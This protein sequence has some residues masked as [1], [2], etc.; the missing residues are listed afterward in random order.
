MKNLIKIIGIAIVIMLVLPFIV[1]KT[2]PADA[3]MAVCFLLFFAANPVVTCVVGI[4]SGKNI[5][6]N[7]YL[8]FVLPII[9]LL[10]SMIIFAIDPAFLMYATVYL[11]LGVVAMTVTAI[12][13]KTGKRRN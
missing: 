11:I 8:V 5:K 2:V 10:S 1:V 3:G 12:I 4:F 13:K 9:F 6:K 7:W